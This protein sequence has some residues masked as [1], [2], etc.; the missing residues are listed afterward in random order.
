MLLVGIISPIVTAATVDLYA[1]SSRGMGVCLSM[2]M[3][4]FGAVAGSNIVAVLL[5]DHC[6][7]TFLLCGSTLIRKLCSQLLEIKFFNDLYFS[8]WLP[9]YINTEYHETQGGRTRNMK[10]NLIIS[11]LFRLQVYVVR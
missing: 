8:V 2:M 3:G 4:R 6:E 9:G 10:W 5:E 7:L 1:T 11:S